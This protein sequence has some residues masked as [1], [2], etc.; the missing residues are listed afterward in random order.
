M[1]LKGLIL[2][3]WLIWL[4]QITTCRIANVVCLYVCVFRQSYRAEFWA[5]VASAKLTEYIWVES[6][7]LSVWASLSSVCSTSHAVD[8]SEFIC[9]VYISILPSLIHT[10]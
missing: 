10:E 4:C 7:S 1:V 2:D 5:D 8:A 9:C 6:S 3:S